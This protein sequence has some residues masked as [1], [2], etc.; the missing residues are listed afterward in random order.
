MGNGAHTDVALQTLMKRYIDKF[1][2]CPSCGLP[3]TEYKIKSNQ[4]SHRCAACG[5]K[6]SIEMSHKLCT[7]I[8]AQDKKAK[9]DG[10]SKDKK[11]KKEDSDE[12][13]KKKKKEKKDKDSDGENADE[14]KKKKKKKEK[15][16]KDADEEK[17]KDEDLVDEM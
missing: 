14:E 2:L 6:E 8:L 10:K 15:K 16:D 13:K 3:E 12:E 1:V 17:K 9:K 11:K 7:Y 5:A 4:I